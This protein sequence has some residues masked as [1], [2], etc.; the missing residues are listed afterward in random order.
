VWEGQPI[1]VQQAL[2]AGRAVVATDVGGT[3]QV[4]GDAAVLVP[5][6]DARALA[7]ALR[8]VLDDP[9]ER[10]RLEAAASARAAALPT[11]EDALAAALEVYRDV[12]DGPSS[13]ARR[14]GL[15]Q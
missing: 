15:V 4:T 12:A 7:Q 2:R 8:R 6:G 3:A 9:A 1:A 11:D 14:P 10:A 13:A 5:G